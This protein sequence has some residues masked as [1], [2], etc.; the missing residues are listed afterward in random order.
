VDALAGVIGGRIRT[1]GPRMMIAALASMFVWFVP[2]S[3]LEEGVSSEPVSE[4]GDPA[5]AGIRRHSER[6]MDG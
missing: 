2:D 1:I 6:F 3:P 5:A 4:V